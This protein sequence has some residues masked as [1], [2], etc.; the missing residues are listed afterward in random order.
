MDRPVELPSQTSAGGPPRRR[1]RVFSVSDQVT[2]SLRDMIFM[3][4]LQGGQQVTHDRIAEILEVSTM[5][6]REALVRLMHEGLI[7]P[8]VK[9]RSFQV[10]V[11]TSDDVRDFYWTHSLIAGEL[12]ARAAVRLTDAQIDE[13][14]QAHEQWIAAA[15]TMNA[16]DLEMA[17]DRFHRIINVGADSPKLN[18]L[19]V[20]ILRLIP[21]QYYAMVPSQVD[22]STRDHG[23]ILD[24]IVARDPLSLIHI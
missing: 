19:L 10:S 16:I 17:N 12:T 15:R 6:V 21:H 9:A 1:R 2:E 5:P 8:G 14:K 22:M 13:L 23:K 20:N 18:R 4:Q 11:T 24:A 3:G 7:E